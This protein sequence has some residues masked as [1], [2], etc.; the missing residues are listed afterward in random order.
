VVDTHTA[1]GFNVFERYA[2][3]SGDSTRT[4]FVST[5]SPFKFCPSVC[6]ALFGNGFSRARSERQ[7]IDVLSSESGMEVPPCLDGLE[8]RPVLHTAVIRPA[9]MREEVLRPF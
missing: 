2:A 7:L 4:I 9:A 5:A 1:V 3:R 8:E 6:D